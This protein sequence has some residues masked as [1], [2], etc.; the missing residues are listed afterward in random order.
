MALI[1][2]IRDDL[3][4][5]IR[6]GDK[7]RRS[8]LRMVLASLKNAEIAQQKPLDEA[9]LIGVI[10][11]EAKQ[12]R[13]SIEAF[14]K[15]NRQDLVLQEEA[16]LVILMEYLPEQVSREEVVAAARKVIDELGAMGPGDRGK[17]MSQLMPQMKGKAE[18]QVVNEVVSELLSSL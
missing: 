6:Q 8:V 12:R 11:K 13:E 16:E 5:A 17:V 9:G 14:N 4:T 15:G 3:E 1:K 10:T 7:T 18:G 2:R